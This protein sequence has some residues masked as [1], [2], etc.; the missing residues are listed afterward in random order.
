MSN[1]ENG[2]GRRWFNGKMNKPSSGYDIGSGPCSREPSIS[3]L[4]AYLTLGFLLLLHLAFALL[5]RFMLLADLLTLSVGCQAGARTEG[6]LGGM[7]VLA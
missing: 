7:P 6:L 5:I 1:G 3:G 4:I 2:P